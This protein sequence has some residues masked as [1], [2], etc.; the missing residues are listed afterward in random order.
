MAI[1]LAN[2]IP[3]EVLF[4][5]RILPFCYDAVWFGSYCR[6][7]GHTAILFCAQEVI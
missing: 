6:F 1:C 2:I 3:N 4:E 5:K 7:N